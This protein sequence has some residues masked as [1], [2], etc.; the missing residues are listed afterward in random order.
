MSVENRNEALNDGQIEINNG[1]FV[2]I[3]GP[4]GVGKGTIVNLLKDRLEQAVFVKSMT[5]RMIRPGEKN[6]DQYFFVSKEEFEEGIKR[7]NFL[8]WAMVHQKDYYGILL[9]PVLKALRQ[10]KLV[11]REVDVQGFE[12]ITRRLPK[13]VF[14]TIFIE[15]ES[16]EILK[17][18]IEHRGHLQP[19]ELER[20]LESVK[21]ELKMADKC[22]FRVIN[23][24]DKLEQ[25]FQEVI[26]IISQNAVQR[27]ITPK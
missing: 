1:L 4:S 3:I 11:I 26:E 21:N 20:R 13:K 23:Y 18:R 2:L 24:Q 7:G 6:G 16:I 22:D 17:Q 5:T 12:Q 10:N 27:G 8:E 19:E 14:L 25:C 15:P 9:E